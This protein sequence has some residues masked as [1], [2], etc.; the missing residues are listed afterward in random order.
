L[1]CGA[2]GCAKGYADAGFEVVGVDIAPQPHYPFKFIQADA[3]TYPLDGF[4]AIHASPVCKGYT[5]LN[6]KGKDNHEK[7]ILPVKKRLL[8]SGKLFVIENVSGAKLELPGALMLCGSMFGMRIQRHRLFESNILMFAPGAC[9]HTQ[10]P[11]S[12]HGHAVWDYAIDGVS[13]EKN[14]K[15]RPASIPYREGAKAMGIDW[16]N[17]DE[18]AQAIPPTYTRW[19]GQFLLAAV[20][21]DC[22]V[23]G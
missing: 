3:M 9:D 22:E 12:I 17:R 4:D 20:Q 13:W 14:G 21:D 19:I 2:G 18:L 23:A 1:F 5:V 6:F 8:A 15:I 10:R 7:L 11:I 16:M